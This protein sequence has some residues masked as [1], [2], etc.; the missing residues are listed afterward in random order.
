[1]WSLEDYKKL[2]LLAGLAGILTLSSPMLMLLVPRPASEQFSELYVLGP[3]RMVENYPLGIEAGITYTIHLGIANYMGVASQYLLTVKLRNPTEHLPN[4][5]LH[6]PSDL[7]PIIAYRV[8]LGD[9][10]TWEKPLNFSLQNI[11]FRE[12]Q[13][14][15]ETISLDGLLHNVE[16]QITPDQED[17]DYFLELFFELWILDPEVQALSF[18]NRWVGLW[19]NVNCTETK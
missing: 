6:M 3:N 1:L 2:F 19:L 8:F 13:C 17:A 15:V 4:S 5:T 14:S 10:E 12:D 9:H 7:P 11:S 18:H 16:K